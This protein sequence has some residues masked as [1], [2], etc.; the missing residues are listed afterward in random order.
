VRFS[1]ARSAGFFSHLFR[2]F[3]VFPPPSKAARE[4]VLLVI[5]RI[6]R[7]SSG[8]SA[9]VRLIGVEPAKA[10]TAILA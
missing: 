2:C 10:V 3:E 6:K 9:D 5:V 7:S 1:S 4:N 8:I